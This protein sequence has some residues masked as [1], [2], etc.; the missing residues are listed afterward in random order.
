MSAMNVKIDKFSG[1]NSF[2]LWQIKMKAL[3]KQQSLWASLSKDKGGDA[4][5]MA[6]LEE[7]AHSTILLCLEDEVIIEVSDETTVAGLWKKLESLYMTKSLQKKLLLK[8]RLFA[9]SMQPDTRLKYH[10]D[11]LNSILLDLHN[12]DVKVE[13]E[14]AALLLLVSLPQSYKNF[15][16][17]FIVNKDKVTLEEVRYAL[18]S[19]ELRRQAGDTATD[20]QAAGLVASGSNGLRHSNNRN[21]RLFSKGPKPDDICNYCK[22]KGHWKF[23]CPKKKQSGSAAVAEDDIKSEHDVA[24]VVGEDTCL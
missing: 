5:E 1:R 19:R 21:K 10:L 9:L 8:R 2:G 20:N 18:H 17:S 22:E 24:L 23:K 13:D 7:K 3:L 16:E 6:T 12:I 4:D 15:V 14:D 11:K